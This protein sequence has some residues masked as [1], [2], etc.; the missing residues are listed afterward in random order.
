MLLSYQP[1]YIRSYFSLLAG[2]LSPEEICR[3]AKRHSYNTVGMVDINNFYGLMRFMFAAE[4][5]GLKAVGGVSVA[6]SGEELFTAYVK[7]RSGFARI[8]QILSRVL[9]TETPYRQC[10]G[11]KTGY[12]SFVRP[13]RQYGVLEDLEQGGWE[14]LVLVSDNLSLLKRLKEQDNHELFVKLIYGKSYYRQARWAEENGLPV[15]AVNEIRFFSGEDRHVY[16]VLR[17]IDLIKPLD[18]LPWDERVSEEAFPIH[19]PASPDE[20]RSYFSPIPSA[21]ENAA[22][23]PERVQTGQLK[24]NSF[25]FPGF[26]GME[27]EE[28]CRYLRVLC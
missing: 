8:N 26:R 22:K 24:S 6:P 1:V 9:V 21:C 15:M 10:R 27:Q 2:C 23:L 16:H 4:R 5:E 11:F 20:M 14:G 7:N 28:T 25:I 17:A 12:C 19:L 18:E 13:G 3:W